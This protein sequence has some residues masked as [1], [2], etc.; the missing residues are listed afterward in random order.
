MDNNRAREVNWRKGLRYWFEWLAVAWC[1]RII[2]LLPLALLH[3]LADL[4]GW[5]AFHLDRKGRAVALANLQAAFGEQRDL[6][7][8][9]AISLRSFQL[10]GRSFLELLTDC[11]NMLG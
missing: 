10:F 11:T 3:L 5:L 9:K 7:D 1:A 8:R 6:S 4:G 2:R